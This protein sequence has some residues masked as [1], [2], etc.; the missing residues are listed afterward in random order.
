MNETVCYSSEVVLS[1]VNEQNCKFCIPL[2]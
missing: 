1:Y 2:C